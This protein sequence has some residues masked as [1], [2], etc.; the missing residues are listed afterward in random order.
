[1]PKSI[2]VIGLRFG[3]LLIVGETEPKFYPDGRSDRRVLARC[4]CGNE[5][6][7]R[8]KQL[9]SGDRRSCG[10]LFM[11]HTR[12][13]KWSTH[14]ESQA[15]RTAEYRAWSAMKSRCTNE[16]HPKFPQYGGR[17]IRVC[18]RWLR[19]YETFV[20]DVGR[21]PSPQHSIDRYP[22]NDGNYEPG[23]VRWATY[24]Q[25]NNNRRNFRPRSS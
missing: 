12:R 10:C 2:D 18:D 6:I 25:Q 5:K 20:A 14:G 11:E 7:V 15:D 4:D 16:K 19:S 1:M 21:R 9:R 3:R 17:G 24:E 23:N 13:R 22:D 8:L